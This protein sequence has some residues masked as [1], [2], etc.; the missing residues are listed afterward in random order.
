MTSASS[1]HEA[2][3]PKLVLSNDPEGQVGRKAG[4]GSGDGGHVYLW[5]IMAKNNTQCCKVIFQLKIINYK[6]K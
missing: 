2:E 4:E 5:L 6:R 3:H 1:V